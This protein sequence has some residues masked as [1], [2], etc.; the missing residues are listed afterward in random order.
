MIGPS[1]SARKGAEPVES[2]QVE[3]PAQKGVSDGLLPFRDLCLGNG[4]SVC[5]VAE[6][7]QMTEMTLSKN[8]HPL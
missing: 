5:E 1:E 7:S 3:M 2:Q 4:N 8:S 6:M